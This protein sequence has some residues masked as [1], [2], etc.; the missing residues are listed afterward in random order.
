MCGQDMIC[1]LPALPADAQAIHA[2][3]CAC[4]AAP[5]SFESVCAGLNK[6]GDWFW[7]AERS[8]AVVGYIGVSLVLDECYVYNLA[9][10]PPHRGR[11]VAK[12]LVLTAC[13]FAFAHGAAFVSLEVRQ[14][15]RA[16]IRLYET[17]GFRKEGERRGFYS[18][19]REDADIMTCWRE[20]QNEAACD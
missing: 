5:W 20:M 1:I 7:K 2:V 6:P 17:C 9:V 8:G 19:P 11:G 14:S 3:E 15:N 13:R 4:F 16:A 10:C 12:R 18:A